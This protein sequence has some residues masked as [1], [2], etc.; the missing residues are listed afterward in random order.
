MGGSAFI[1]PL[2]NGVTVLGSNPSVGL[3]QEG[4]EPHPS[5]VLQVCN[6]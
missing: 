4:G 2:H 1:S 5:E 3:H 6:F